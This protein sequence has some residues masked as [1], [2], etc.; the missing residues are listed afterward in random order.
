MGH[1]RDR[2]AGRTALLI[3]HDPV[4]AARFDGPHVSLGGPR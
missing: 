1:V 2:L 3:T 4:E